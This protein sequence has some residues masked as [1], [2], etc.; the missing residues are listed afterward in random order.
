MF[1]QDCNEFKAGEVVNMMRS[2]GKNKLYDEKGVFG[3]V[4]RHNYPKGF[5]DIKRGER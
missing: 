4:C 5:L 3:R 1:L 2:K